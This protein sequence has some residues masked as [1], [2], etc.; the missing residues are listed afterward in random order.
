MAQTIIPRN[1]PKAVIRYMGERTLS[2]RERSK[3]QRRLNMENKKYFKKRRL[4]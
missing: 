2:E 4:R 1:D 3:A